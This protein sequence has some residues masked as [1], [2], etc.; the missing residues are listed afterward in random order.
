MTKTK[1]SNQDV[2]QSLNI[3]TIKTC[4]VQDVVDEIDRC[5]SDYNNLVDRQH[6]ALQLSKKVILG[7][8][9]L[10]DEVHSDA[11]TISGKLNKKKH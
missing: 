9:S 1:D 7:Q 4:T 3:A 8:Q 5:A 10:I 2:E 6:K 11:G